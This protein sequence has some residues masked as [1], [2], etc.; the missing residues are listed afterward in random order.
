MAKL[1]PPPPP[2]SEFPKQ[3]SIA[4]LPIS[5]LPNPPSKPTLVDKLKLISILDDRAILCFSNSTIRSKNK[6]PRTLTLSPG[7]QFESVSVISVDHDSVTLQ[8]D[9]ER[10]VKTLERV[11]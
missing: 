8:E 2:S 11:R 9:G 3:D 1:V 7:D 5:I 4:N 10:S 6:W